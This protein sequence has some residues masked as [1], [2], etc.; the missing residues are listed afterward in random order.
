MNVPLRAF[1]AR[2]FTRLGRRVRAE[3]MMPRAILAA[4]R[5]RAIR[6]TQKNT[7]RGISDSPDFLAHFLLKGPHLG[8]V[9][10]HQIEVGGRLRDAR[11]LAN[12]FQHQLP[13]ATPSTPN[14]TPKEAGNVCH[15][16]IPIEVD[17]RQYGK[18]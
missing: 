4:L 6:V 3:M 5:F 18:V 10:G 12:V 14:C 1:I 13:P 9:V 16:M 11:L 8:D 15:Q 17:H 2:R 7:P